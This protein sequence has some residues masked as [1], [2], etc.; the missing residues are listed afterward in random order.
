MRWRWRFQNFIKTKT[1]RQSAPRNSLCNIAAIRWLPRGKNHLPLIQYMLIDSNLEYLIFPK[2]VIVTDMN[3]TL[4]GIFRAIE[5]ASKNDMPL[6]IHYKSIVK[7]YW[8]P[9]KDS[10]QFHK[11]IN[12]YLEKQSLPDTYKTSFLL[13]KEYLKQFK[14]ALYFLDIDCKTKGYAYVAHL[15]T[16]ALNVTK[17]RVETVIKQMLKKKYGVKRL[18]GEFIDKFDEFHSML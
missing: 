5:R 1:K 11:K 9:R 3:E 15:W 2:E 8:T 7:G 4:E 14:R 10:A 16:I 12:Q 17:G 13:K 6:A 18:T